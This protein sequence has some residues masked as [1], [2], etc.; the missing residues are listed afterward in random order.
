[1]AVFTL[2]SGRDHHFKERA[3]KRSFLFS[4]GVHVAILIAAGSMTLFRM[5]GTNYAPSYTVDLV[6]LP[7]APKTAPAKAAAT[8]APQPVKPAV[9]KKE[10][11]KAVQPPAENVADKLKA[12]GGDEAARAERLERIKELEMEASR[13]YESFTTEEEAAAAEEGATPAATSADG[14]PVTGAASGGNETPSNLRFRAYYDRIWTEIRSSW[15]VPEGVTSSVSLETVVGIRIVASG[16]IEQ[17]RIEERS[18]NEYYDQSA[19]RA[20]RKA[21]LPPLPEELSDKP[22]EV[23]INFRYPE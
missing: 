10:S 13:L 11:R 6:S 19:L 5:S 12:S 1:L 17:F 2:P 3:F 21:K 16:Q 8:K 9:D 14:P 20:I 18:G 7:P 23:G 15:V 4:F 22:L